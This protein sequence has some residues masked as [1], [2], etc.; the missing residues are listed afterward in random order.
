MTE[1]KD[2]HQDQE[3]NNERTFLHKAANL[4]AYIQG[5]SILLQKTLEKSVAE[6]IEFDREKALRQVKKTV[7]SAD[8]LVSELVERRN[9]VRSKLGLPPVENP[10]NS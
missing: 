1:A 2:L 9:H 3:I 7:E 5:Q 10:S 6:G 8:E 4:L